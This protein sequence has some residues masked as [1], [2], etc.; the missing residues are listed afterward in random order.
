M[1]PFVIFLISLAVL[2]SSCSDEE[3]DMRLSNL[4]TP[5]VTGYEWRDLNAQLVK[6]IGTPNIKLGNESNDYSSAY[7]FKSYP[8]PC[9]DEL[10]VFVKMPNPDQTIKSWIVQAQYTDQVTN[11]PNQI[12]NSVTMHAGGAS[13]LQ[14]EFSGNVTIFDVSELK[15]GYYRLYLRVD[16]ILLYDNIYVNR[17]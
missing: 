6:T 1:K 3:A 12:G 11:S 10:A 15:N 16:G 5:V 13:I 2:V 7:Y 17:N 14:Q 4:E 8:N 9:S